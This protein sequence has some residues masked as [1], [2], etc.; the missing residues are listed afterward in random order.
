MESNTFWTHGLL[1]MGLFSL[2]VIMNI[3]IYSKK[4]CPNYTIAKQLLES[5]GLNYKEI[6][7]EVGDR[8]ANFVA[9][10]SEAK[11]MPQ[12][13]VGDQRVGGLAG[14]QAALKQLEVL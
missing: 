4:N 6:D 8:L 1:V 13:W 11:Q 10:Y 9:N 14:L 7:I 5:K 2:D 12:I 3:T